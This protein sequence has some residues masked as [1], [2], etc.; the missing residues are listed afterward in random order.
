[1]AIAMYSRVVRGGGWFESVPLWVHA[2]C[3]LWLAH[4]AQ[5]FGVGVRCVVYL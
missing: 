1:M 4:G 5:S 3:L 2:A